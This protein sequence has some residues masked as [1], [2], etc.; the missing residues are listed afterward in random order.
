MM[1]NIKIFLQESRQ[2]FSRVNWPTLSETVRLTTMVVV[3][4]LGVAAFLGIADFAF[5]ALLSK[6]IEYRSL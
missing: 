1:Q 3:M 4:S 6:V 2:E 5:T